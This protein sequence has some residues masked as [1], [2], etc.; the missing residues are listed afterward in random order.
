MDVQA[1]GSRTLQI[2]ETPALF[3]AGRAFSF[4]NRQGNSIMAKTITR[5]GPKPRNP[6]DTLTQAESFK[7][8]GETRRKL[9]VLVQ[10][11]GVSKGEFIRRLIDR[12]YKEIA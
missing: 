1:D 11:E 7:A 4:R 2:V 9:R 10:R 3:I 5:S 12:A 8:D 6:D